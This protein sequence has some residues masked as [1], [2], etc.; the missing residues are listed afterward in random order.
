LT[1]AASDQKA[2]RNI[3]QGGVEKVSKEGHGMEDEKAKVGIYN[4]DLK[5]IED[6]QKY[7]GV[8]A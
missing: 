5:L 3:L 8:F 1:N 4:V 7:G 2:S 6:V